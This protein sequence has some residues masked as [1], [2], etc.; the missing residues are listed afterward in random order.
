MI[1]RSVTR[2]RRHKYAGQLLDG[3]SGQVTLVVDN[4]TILREISMALRARS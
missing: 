1:C 3:A 4:V 2:G